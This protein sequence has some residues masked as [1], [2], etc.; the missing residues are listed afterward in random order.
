MHESCEC[1]PAW[2]PAVLSQAGRHCERNRAILY[3]CKPYRA[4]V[5]QLLKRFIRTVYSY[6]K[7]DSPIDIGSQDDLLLLMKYYRIRAIVE[8]RLYIETIEAKDLASAFKILIKRAADGLVK[9]KETVGFYQRKQ[10]Q[11]TYEEV[12]DG[13]TTISANEVRPGT[14]VG[15]EGFD[16]AT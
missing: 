12:T 7:R 14:Q 3:R 13:T 15:K 16:I 6:I 5:I 11:L 2:R 8:G 10:V 4:R 9:V 1:L